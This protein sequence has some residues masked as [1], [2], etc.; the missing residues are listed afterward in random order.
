MKLCNHTAIIVFLVS[1]QDKQRQSSVNASYNS[2]ENHCFSREGKI[3]CCFSAMHRS[4][5]RLFTI[6]IPLFQTHLKNVEHRKK[7]IEQLKRQTTL[8]S[9]KTAVLD[10]Q[11]SDMEVTVADR[12][13]IHDRIG[14]YYYGTK[15]NTS[16]DLCA[17]SLI[18]AT[19][20]PSL[21]AEERYQEIV[22]RKKL[23]DLAQAQAEE[24]TF[25][26]AEVERLR[27]KNFPS[28]NQLQHH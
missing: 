16:N 14:I 5:T 25:L 3:A 18:V 7:K 21:K 4:C 11:L 27:T 23:K 19:D 6:L 13:H 12:K 22:Q 15:Y 20:D 1:P 10:V 17:F 8:T 9:D 2:G 28:L 24:M 26:W